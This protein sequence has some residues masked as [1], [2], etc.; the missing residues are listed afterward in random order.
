M[1]RAPCLVNAKSGLRDNSC[2][3][4]N[5]CAGLFEGQLWEG[6]HHFRRVDQQCTLS[7][8]R[9][10]FVTEH[11]IFPNGKDSFLV[12]LRKLFVQIVERTL[13]IDML[14]S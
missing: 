7:T 5:S 11:C 2:C 8:F 13:H 9:S 10:T 12:P 3:V 1:H 14:S 4:V 6:E